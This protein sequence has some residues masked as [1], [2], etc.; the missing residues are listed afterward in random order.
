MFKK[1][2]FGFIFL[3]TAGLLIFFTVLPTLVEKHK[4]TVTGIGLLPIENKTR[5]LH[6]E[7]VI[8]D[9]HA[10]SLLWGRDLSKRSDRGM[11]DFPRMRE[12]NHALQVFSVVTKTPRGLNITRNN[13]DT[14]NI[15][16]LAIA[17]RWPWRTYTSL[18]ERALYQAERLH[19]MSAQSDGQFEIITNR[20]QLADFLQRR[21]KRPELSGGLLALEGAQALEGNLENLQKI[22][23]AG[24]RIISPA[25]FFDTEVGGSAHGW[26][27]GGLT[28]FGKQW[29]KKMD[30]ACLIIDLSHASKKVFNEILA[31]TTRPVVVSHTGVKGTCRNNR[32]LSDAQ[33]KKVA[34]N[35]GLIGIGFWSVATCGDK[36]ADIARAIKYAVSVAGVEH[37][38]LGSDFDGA[39]ALPF[40]V[41]AMVQITQALKN[42]GFTGS[43]IEARV[44][45]LN[46]VTAHILI[47]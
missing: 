35:G 18:T 19:K 28:E 27:K 41:S 34:E 8:A 32:N 5:Q 37:V 22:S 21:K 26:H 20:T 23:A 7:L 43:E 44:C 47:P 45:K 38:A 46:C 31:L 16:L 2:L 25:H 4:N 6:K 40:D 29:V 10:D 33:I 11:V 42:K 13:N 14:D 15:T 3:L 17:Q 9:L 30:R 12:G 24:Y 39:V 1:I 36:P